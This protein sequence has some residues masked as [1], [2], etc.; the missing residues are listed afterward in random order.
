[1]STDLNV[2]LLRE[3]MPS[4]EDWASA[5]AAAGYGVQLPVDFDAYEHTGYLP[6]KWRGLDTGFEYY[7]SNLTPDSANDPEIEPEQLKMFAAPS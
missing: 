7:S 2:F 6:C 5:V 3:Q 1:M 4:T